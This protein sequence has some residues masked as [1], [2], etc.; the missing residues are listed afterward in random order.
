[1][2]ALLDRKKLMFEFCQW[3]QWWGKLWFARIVLF[4]FVCFELRP[5]AV[6]L[7]LHWLCFDFVLFA[8]LWVCIDFSVIALTSAGQCTAFPVCSC[9]NQWSILQAT[10]LLSNGDVC[11][12]SL[13]MKVCFTFGSHIAS[14]IRL[15][16]RTKQ[17]PRFLSGE[18]YA[19]G[20][21]F[22][23]FPNMRL[24]LAMGFQLQAAIDM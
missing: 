4:F 13:G 11:E 22:Y 14:S 19:E 20:F 12:V 18:D 3:R 6:S 7:I 5:Y 1:M 23:N 24:L 21:M 17:F 2:F 9:W 16:C 8:F 10:M 15:S